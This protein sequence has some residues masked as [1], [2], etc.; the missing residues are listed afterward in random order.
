MPKMSL[1]KGQ[2]WDKV[3]EADLILEGQYP[4]RIDNVEER[5]NPETDKTTWGVT[6]TLLD[7]PYT[8]RKVFSNFG[9]GATALWKLK[10]L[11]DAIGL[12]LTGRSDLDSA[13]ILNAEVG[14]NVTHEM[15]EGRVR[16][17][18]ETYFSLKG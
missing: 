11:A 2:D 7:E 15:Y 10:L 14:V 5:V 8:G 12:D 1:P 3:A 18:A 4:A 6:F 13:E 17:R 16:N 9:L